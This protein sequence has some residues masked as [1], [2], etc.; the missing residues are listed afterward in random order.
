MRERVVLSIGDAM[1]PHGGILDR[2][3]MA[4]PEGVFRSK[5]EIG[6]QT[7]KGIF[8]AFASTANP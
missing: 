1:P 4:S 7:T 8:C 2:M 6:A 5:V 3:G